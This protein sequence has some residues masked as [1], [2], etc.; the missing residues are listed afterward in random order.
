MNGERG[1]ND[2][3]TSIHANE[4]CKVFRLAGPASRDFRRR[5]SRDKVARI[6]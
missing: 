4:R 1:T 5:P 3:D 2:E 6:K